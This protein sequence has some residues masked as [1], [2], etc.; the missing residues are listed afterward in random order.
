MEKEIFKDIPGY[1]GLYQ[2][3]NIG[4]VKSLGNTKNRKEKILKPGIIN[5]YLHVILHKNSKQK[6]FRV[7]QL[8]AMAFLGHTPNGY[9]IVVN[10]KDNNELNNYVDN[11]E[12]VSNRYNSSCHKTDVGIYWK[13]INNKWIASITINRKTI[14][15]GSFNEKE[16]ASR[17]YQKAVVKIHLYNGDA[18]EFRKLLK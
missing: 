9:E 7:H 3:S 14:Y 10:H 15:L 6:S 13:E 16:E 4:G 5:G 11:L 18:K 2:V 8:V 12:L 17:V 1:E